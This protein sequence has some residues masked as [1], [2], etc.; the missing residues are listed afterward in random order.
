MEYEARIGLTLRLFISR[1]VQL[2]CLK[3]IFPIIYGLC[4]LGHMY[5]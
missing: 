5:V 2:I 1:I 4:G 3:A